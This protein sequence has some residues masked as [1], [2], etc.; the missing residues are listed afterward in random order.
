M[1]EFRRG[2]LAL[3]E[4]AN[5]LSDKEWEQTQIK[6]FTKWCNLYLAKRGLEIHNIATDFDNGIKLI[7]LL[8]VISDSKL[9]KY[10]R[11]PKMKINEIANLN[12]AHE[13]LKNFYAEVKIKVVPS[14]EQIN[15]HDLKAILGLIWVLILRFSIADIDE[16]GLAAKEGLLLWCQRNTAGYEGVDPPGI[17]D[18]HRSWKTGLGFAALINKFRPDLLNYNDLDKSDPKHV[19]Q[20]AFDVAQSRLNIPPLLDPEDIY[21]VEKPDEK[22]IMTYLAQYWKVFSADTKIYLATKRLNRAIARRLV[23][24]SMRDE[25]LAI[26]HEFLD[27]TDHEVKILEAKVYGDSFDTLRNQYFDF[28]EFKVTLKSHLLSLKI[29]AESAYHGLAAKLQSEKFPPYDAPAGQSLADLNAKFDYMLSLE[30]PYEAGLTSALTELFRGTFAHFDKNKTNSISRDEL[31]ACF[32]SLSLELTPADADKI[33]G[34]IHEI[35]FEKFVGCMMERLVDSSDSHQILEACKIVS[36]EKLY[37]DAGDLSSALGVREFEW[38]RN[39]GCNFEG[40]ENSIDVNRLTEAVFAP[41]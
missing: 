14:P 20:V 15:Q 38:V 39:A 13:F 21:G 23:N 25:Y 30:V 41:L 17:Q 35:P 11:T 18:F 6:T 9:G 8:E 33:F 36:R 22:S 24:A 26:A 2:T 5:T 10:N 19:L 12:L 28:E 3:S 37:V 16:G 32:S 1:S 7:N 34:E 29:R 27:K 40:D 31:Q 4:V